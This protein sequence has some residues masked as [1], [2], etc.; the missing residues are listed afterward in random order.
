VSAHRLRFLLRRSAQAVLTLWGLT[1]ILFLIFHALPGSAAQSMLGIRTTRTD[2]AK[3]NAQLGLDRPLWTQYWSYLGR[4]VHGDLGTSVTYHRPALDVI[5]S[6]LPTTLELA[7]YAIVLTAVVT[8]VLATVAAMHR[9][10]PIDHLIRSVP[11]I[12]LGMPAFW[13]GTMLLFLFAL[14]V[15][16][17]PAGGL[18]PGI[19][20]RLRS[21]LLPALTL[22][23]LFSAILVRSLRAS[24]LE[25]L[26]SDHVITA[27][28]KGLSGAR[29]VLRHVLPNAALPTITLL[30]LIFAGLLGGALIVE[31]VFALPGVGALLVNG[32]QEHDFAVVQGITL[33]SAVAILVMNIA[34]DLIYSALDPRVGVS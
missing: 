25:V 28:A 2:I 23:V 1:L 18:Q 13:I 21:L 27:R 15:P 6:S 3:I 9:D 32:F 20:G 29:L 11:V 17:F 14:K 8:T 10:K 33:F 22:T 12:G 24:L 19:E 4:L 7:G 16:L 5:K 26:E 31:S 34:I 30:G